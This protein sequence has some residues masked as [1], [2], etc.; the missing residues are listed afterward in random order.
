M[1]ILPGSGIKEHGEGIDVRLIPGKTKVKLELFKGITIVDVLVALVGLGIAAL[2]AVSSLPYRWI[3]AIFVMGI[4]GML[5]VRVND[6]PIYVFFWHMLR[7]RAFPRRFYRVFD[8]K[9]LKNMKGKDRE[10]LMDDFY[11]A[12]SEENE[13]SDE[14]EEK[15]SVDEKKALKELIKE[16]NKILKSKTATKEEKDAVWL[17]RA[18]RSAAKKKEKAESKED[19]S[20]YADVSDFIPFTGIKDGFIEYADEYVGAV[21]EID[22][23]EFRFHSSYRRNNAIENCFGKV[24]R[25]LNGAYGVNIVKLQRPIIYE[26]YLESEYAKLDAL[27]KSYESGLLREDELKARVEVE[28]ARI[29]EISALCTDDL[30]IEGF[31]YLVLF[32]RDRRNLRMITNQALEALEQA[33]LSV[34]RLDDR[35]LALFLKYS[36]TLD[37]D[38]HDIDSIDPEHWAEWAMPEKLK[39]S[40][41]KIEVGGLITHNFRVI[42]YPSVVGDAWLAGVMSFPA[43]KVVVKVTPMDR[44]KSIRAIDRSLAELR[45]RYISTGI[46]SKRLELQTHIET[47]SSLLVTLQQ[48][49]EALLSV[50]IYVTGYDA[51]ATKEDPVLGEGF[52]S[53]CPMIPDMRKTVRHTWTEAGMKLSQM[54]FMQ[55]QAFIGSQISNYDPMVKEARGIPSNTIAG[56]YPWIF[57]HVSDEGGVKLGSSDGIPVFINFFRRD[58]E[59]VNSNM[60]IVGKSGSGKSYTTKS[61]LLNLASEDSKIF[62]LDPENEYSELAH[63]LHGRIINVGNAKYGRLN[64]FHI[65]TALDD[66]EAGEG[67]GGPA[68]SFATH[69]QFLEEFFRQILPDIDK[70]ALEY[71]NSLVERTYLNFGITPETDLSVLHAEDYPV[72]D[73]LYDVILAEF[74]RTNNDYLRQMLRTLVNYIS[75][76]STGGRNA[77]I[78]NGPSTITTDEN[79]S[80]FNFQSLLANRNSTIANAQMLLVLKYIDNE[81]IKN[82]D[83]NLRY[84]LKRKIVVVIDEAH[85]FIDTK[86]P[87]ALDFMFQLAKRIRKYNG[88]QIVITQNIKDFVGSEEIARKS[89]A[90]INACQYSFVFG[91]APNDMDDLCKLYEKAGGINEQEQEDILSAKRGQAFAIMSPTSRTSFH[92]DVPELFVDMFENPEFETVYFAGEEGDQVWEEFIEDSRELHDANLNDRLIYE[93]EH[94][95]VEG[96]RPPEDEPGSTLNFSEVTEEELLR[97][98]EE[99]RRE[100]PVSAVNKMLAAEEAVNRREYEMAT[101]RFGGIRLEEVDGLAGEGYGGEGYGGDGY[102]GDG[103]GSDGYGDAGYGGDGYGSDE[104]SGEDGEWY[105]DEGYAETDYAGDGYEGN[106]GAGGYA[107]ENGGAYRENVAQRGPSVAYTDAMLEEKLSRFRASIRAEM[108]K[109]LMERLKWISI[110]ASLGNGSGLNGAAF[111]AAAQAAGQASGSGENAGYYDAY[112]GAGD[113]YGETG[114]TYAGVDAGYAESEEAYAGAGDGYG[115]TGEAYAGVDAGYGETGEAYAGV[116]AGDESAADLFSEDESEDEEFTVDAD[117]LFSESGEDEILGSDEDDIFGSDE[118]DIP[119]SEED[120]D[121]ALEDDEEAES[122]ESYESLDDDEDENLE[123][124]ASGLF[125]LDDSEEDDLLDD[126]DLNM[127]RMNHDFDYDLEDDSDLNDDPDLDEDGEFDDD[128]FSDDL[129]EYDDDDDFDLDD[130][131]LDD[132]DDFGHTPFLFAELLE[133]A[134]EE[135]AEMDLDERMAESGEEVMEITLDELS[136]YIRDLHKKKKGA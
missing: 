91:L 124:D 47:L 89:T 46:D 99:Q 62:I 79:F 48:E 123:M 34:R 55:L 3:I 21:I 50:N 1:G 58:S 90:I 63:N 127:D 103:Y 26:R 82:R 106:Y 92:I 22:P 113:G 23:V 41:R 78:W 129:S 117:S 105:G 115:E 44:S 133:K 95:G 2:C 114:E 38:E 76:F 94:P 120:Y 28:E 125:H 8:D 54:D 75:K 69:L 98:Q 13:E 12:E 104:Y 53:R 15:N 52:K 80:V 30:V 33:E 18:N 66:D 61:L 56:M 39:F 6:S 14:E 10:Q 86:F 102:G 35:G 60:V 42:N 72:F 57:A 73:D 51:L 93:E 96:I 24:L 31:Y 131:D 134:A 116:D 65:I 17:A 83:Y 40:A 87:V 130:D 81:I 43:T 70:D 37:F 108:E 7:Y 25:G 49:N 97:E 71:L 32:E 64:P 128:E 101:M 36:N 74:E 100:A 29:S 5:I 84:N 77:N 68:G 9:A 132:D 118:D 59:R 27:K 112:A 67:G 136:Q 4:F 88:M 121:S 135:Y 111:D 126:E 45:G 20:N 85:V 11:K 119:G 16:E 19:T 109:E 107:P 110:G 122:D